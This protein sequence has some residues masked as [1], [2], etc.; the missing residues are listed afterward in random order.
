M[1]SGP[2][3]TVESCVQYRRLRAFR[4]TKNC[5]LAAGGSSSGLHPGGVTPQERLTLYMAVA[6]CYFAVVVAQ[7]RCTVFLLFAG[8]G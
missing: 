7:C 2:D 3:A 8:C 1:D 4:A 6:R 5:L